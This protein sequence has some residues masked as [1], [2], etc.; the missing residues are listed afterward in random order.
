[1][2]SLPHSPG[3]V[4]EA[5]APLCSPG[6]RR[7]GTPFLLLDPVVKDIATKHSSTSAQVTKFLLFILFFKVIITEAR[8]NQREEVINM[9]LFI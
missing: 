3:I 2:T 1:M 9:Q 8:A 4:F 6:R 5:Y 7:D